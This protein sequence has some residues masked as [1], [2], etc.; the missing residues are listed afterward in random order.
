MLKLGSL[1]VN[2]SPV[3]ISSSAVY[4]KASRQ[5]VADFMQA[6]R[7]WRGTVDAFLTGEATENGV[8]DRLVELVEAIKNNRDTIELLTAGKVSADDI[9]NDLTTGGTKKVLS[10]EQGKALKALVDAVHVFEN[11]ETLDAIS[12]NAETG[13]LVFN[14]H[15]L[16]G[17]T[18]I[19]VGASSEAATDY[20]AKIQILVEDFDDAAA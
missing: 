15:E 3:N 14:G 17:E 12:K 8:M 5:S 4:D 18:G 6:Y 19:A 7:A 11:Q 20:T 1:M 13:N 2:G 10:A 9:V 16:N